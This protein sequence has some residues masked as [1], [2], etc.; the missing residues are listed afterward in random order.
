[1]AA[2][3]TTPNGSLSLY[4]IHAGQSYQGKNFADICSSTK[5]SYRC[6]GP[7]ATSK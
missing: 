6:G 7:V 2:T 4:N 3:V 5:A 1:M